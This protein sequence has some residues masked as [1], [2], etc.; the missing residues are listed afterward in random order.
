MKK[1][2]ILLTLSL[3]VAA[4]QSCKKPPLPVLEEPVNTGGN[5]SGEEEEEEEEPSPFVGTWSYTKIDL[6]NG[7]LE[8]MGNEVGEFTGTGKDIDG[9]V[10][11]SENP[12]RYTT[13]LDFTAEIEFDLFGQTQTQDSPIDNQASSGT[14]T[15]TDG[16]IVLTDD[17]GQEIG[18]L[19]SSESR[20]VFTGEFSTQIPLQ[21]F[22]IDATSDVVF[23]IEK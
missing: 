4:T 9:E 10:V 14:W 12:N 11:I 8:A 17:S 15:E 5:G 18:I 2:L 21:F 1:I 20:I 7:S 22:T 19:S 3:T 16:Q 13:D 23:T 6:T